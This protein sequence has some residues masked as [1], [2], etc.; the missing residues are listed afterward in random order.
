[1]LTV[2]GKPYAIRAAGPVRLQQLAETQLGSP[3]QIVDLVTYSGRMAHDARSPPLRNLELIE[4]SR[5]DRS[6][7]LLERAGLHA[8]DVDGS[9]LLLRRWLGQPLVDVAEID[10]RLHVVALFVDQTLIRARLREAPRIGLRRRAADQ[11]RGDR[12]FWST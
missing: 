8:R 5:G 12:R 3:R 11:S 1:M 9:A 10:S 2:A 4:T 6:H 7:S